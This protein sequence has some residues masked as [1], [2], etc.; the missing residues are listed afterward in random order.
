MLM[1]IIRALFMTL[2]FVLF[3]IY[4][5]EDVRPFESIIMYLILVGFK[6]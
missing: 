6:W 4:L 5:G 1:N 2:F 3:C